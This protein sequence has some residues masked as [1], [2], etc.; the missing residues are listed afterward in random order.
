[1]LGKIKAA[2]RGHGRPG[3]SAVDE[4]SEPSLDTPLI[5]FMF[6]ARVLSFIERRGLETIRD[7]VALAPD[8]LHLEKNF[9]RTSIAELRETI[10]TVTGTTWE[11]ARTRSVADARGR[12]SVGAVPPRFNTPLTE[13]TFSARVWSFI[14]RRGLE[15]IRDA[16]AMAPDKLHLVKNFGRLSIAELRETIEAVTETSWEEARAELLLDASDGAG[17]EAEALAAPAWVRLGRRLAE[18]HR[19]L[20]VTALRGFPTRMKR[21]AAER[22]ISTL[23]ALFD[24]PVDELRNAR[25]L[26]RKS[27]ADTLEVVVALLDRAPESLPPPPPAPSIDHHADFAALWRALLGGL[28]R[29][30][31]II[32]QHRSGYGTPAS[33]LAEIGEMLGV[34]GERVR[35]IEARALRDLG[36]QR[37]WIDELDARVAAHLGDGACAIDE[38][39]AVDPWFAPLC[40][41]DAVFSFVNERFLEGRYAILVKDDGPFIA[42]FT[43]GTLDGVW[44]AM[45]EALIG[46]PWPADRTTIDALIDAKAAPLGAAATRWLRAK[47]LER[48]MPDADND[49]LFAGYGGTRG[50]EIRLWLRAAGAPVPVSEVTRAF[51]RGRL[52]EDV[53]FADRGMVT[54]AEVLEGFD[55]CIERVVPRCVAHMTA[56]GAD[57]QW[58]CH[59]LASVVRE[60]PGLPEWFGPWPLAALV[61]RSPLLRYLGRGIVAL[62]HVDG[63][64]V[65]VRRLLVNLLEAAGRP[66]AGDD[67]RRRASVHRAITALSFEVT[68]QRAPF[69]ELAHEVYGLAARDVPGGVAAIRRGTD[70]VAE[71]LDARG[72]G[73]SLVEA[74]RRIRASSVVFESW[75]ETMMRS[76]CA[77]DARLQTSISRAVGLSEW[78]DLRIPT[79]KEIV[80]QALAAGEGRAEVASLLAR[81]EAIYGESVS[82]KSIAAMAWQCN[83]RLEGEFLIARDPIAR[84]SCDPLLVDVPVDVA[85]RFEV[86]IAEDLPLEDPD[87]AVVAHV[88]RFFLDAVTNEAI[89]LSRVL[90]AQALCE[91]L[92][93]RASASD[94]RA[95]ALARAAVRYFVM[96][97]DGAWDFTAK[98]LDDDLAVLRAVSA[99]IDRGVHE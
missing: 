12:A 30:D 19:A 38:M 33:T 86:L 1:M 83:A 8:K 10:E 2:T 50:R 16:V 96:S 76:F 43:Q 15:T 49:A 18:H 77:Q 66:L 37:W 34:S 3:G 17:G 9:G 55:A 25:N 32:L 45:D 73:M 4:P 60:E 53:V 57:R 71:M 92:I 42:R 48:L 14:E 91:S 67:L 24:L 52:P 68:M 31:R 46:H 72:C 51:G 47:A 40:E 61:Q 79:R 62:P 28:E 87:A 35:Q 80:V 93:A 70:L 85:T 56:H 81:I 98:G 84:S 75:T 95:R 82:R 63:E 23:G 20:P 58:S 94:D 7:A 13:F 99:L 78:E 41:N 88:R 39:A 90:E 97:D 26:G 11:E 54:V 44:A 36:A 6:S 74:L 65:Y 5:E 69:V 59:E 64:R 27:I 21:F 29:V 22:G 89:D